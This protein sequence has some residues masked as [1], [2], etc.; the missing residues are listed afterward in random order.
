MNIKLKAFFALAAIAI[1]LIP[2]AEAQNTNR[3]PGTVIGW[4]GQVIPIVAPGTRFTKI[5]AGYNHSLALKSD[6]TV[7]AWGLNTTGQTN[8]PPGLTNV[9]AISA[10]QTFS[11]ALIGSGPPITH[12]LLTSPAAGSNTFSLS[13]PTESGKVYVLE[14]KQALSDP[15]WAILPLV[16]G[17]GGVL[18]LTDSAAT[19]SQ[20]FYRVQRW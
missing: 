15:G 7:V 12:A 6:G 1:A 20:R 5:A 16:S 18:R 3:T 13:L 17:N 10:G 4:G 14:W 8:V 9:I 19:N 11:M 2:Q